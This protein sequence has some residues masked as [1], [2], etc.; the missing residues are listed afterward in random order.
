MLKLYGFG[1][2]FGLADPSPFVLKVDAWLRMAEIPYQ[3]IAGV[4]Y[5]RQ[6]PKGKLPFIEDAGQK[7]GDSFFILNYLKQQYGNPLDASLSPEQL[8]ISRLIIRSLDENFYWCLIQ[9][10]WV[11]DESWPEVKAAF[12]GAM[13]F[14]LKHIVALVA[15]H[16]TCSAFLKQGMGRH[17]EAE[18]LAIAEETLSSLS[19]LLGSKDYFFG[20]RPSTLDAVAFGFLAQVILASL[21]SPLRQLACGYGNLVDYCKRIETRYYR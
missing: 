10:R 14:P 5:L 17:S 20:E 3:L 15:R 11:R 1:A 21:D 6:A 9:S 16:S 7:I 4:E 13:P 2:K 18:I 19:V 8:A 12:F